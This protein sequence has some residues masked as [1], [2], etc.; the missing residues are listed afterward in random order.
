M[1]FRLTATA[2]GVTLLLLATTA[3]ILL[4][5]EDR[6]LLGRLDR[7][8]VQRADALEPELAAGRL[9]DAGV[10]ANDDPDRGVQV[11][12]LTGRVLVAT[13]NL[14]DSPPLMAP[15][16]VPEREAVSTRADLP[17][18]TDDYRVMTRRVETPDGPAVLFVVENNDDINDTVENL[19]RTLVVVLP[20]LGI[21]LVALLW[22]LTG[23]ALRPVEAIRSEVA[24]IDSAEHGRRLRV[25]DRVD[26]I[27]L[28][29]TTM[30]AMLQRL[31]E[32]TDRQRRFVADAAHELRT[33][34]TRMQVAADLAAANP[35]ELSDSM[36]TTRLETTRMRQLVEDLLFL[37]RADAGQVTAGHSEIDLDDLVMTEIR[38][39]RSTAT[40][41]IDAS[42][43]SAA[44]VRGRPSD[45]ARAVA[46]VVENAVRHADRQVGVSLTHHDGRVELVVRDD[47]KGIRPEDR[48]RVFERFTRLDE[49]RSTSD[50]G[51]G[52]GLAIA[53]DIV[54]RHGGTL[55]CE[56]GR[57]GAR[58]V[59]RLPMPP[60]T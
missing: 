33:P 37:A 11:V 15:E 24:A 38:A 50:G 1:R 10:V 23:R 34:L 12:D 16:A 40:C 22:W 56:D 39:A 42:A 60:V 14:A 32:S 48:E 36:E 17:I 57:P 4:S 54:E 2:A 49:A 59:M 30:N 44:S 28:L 21:I 13:E 25:P 26:E 41:R 55:T 29:A 35:D 20:V 27:G 9:A 43:V 5:V 52:L 46:N 3:A 6:Q 18:S 7:S 47:G 58:F 53:R 45:L 51:A 8:L 19:L 31:D